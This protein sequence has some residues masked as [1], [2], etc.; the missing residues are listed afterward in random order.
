MDHSEFSLFQL[1]LK[2]IFLLISGEPLRLERNEA[3]VR[4]EKKRGACENRVKRQG[5]SGKII[6]VQ[7]LRQ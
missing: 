6:L 3:Y 1:L 7:K 5:R 4:F 2:V